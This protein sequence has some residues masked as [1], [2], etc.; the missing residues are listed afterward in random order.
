M[1]DYVEST[2]QT[3]EMVITNLHRAANLIRNFKEVAADQNDEQKRVFTLYGYIESLLR[4]LE[5]ELKSFKISVDLSGDK[6]VQLNSYPSAYSQIITNFIINSLK[7]GFKRQHQ[8][9]ISIAFEIH[10]D[11]LLLRY[12]DDGRGIDANTLPK[13]FD[14]FFT[15]QRTAGGT[16]LGLHIV[17]NI[18]NQRLG[19]TIDASSEVGAGVEFTIRVPLIPPTKAPSRA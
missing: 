1:N 11:T 15:T 4:S 3:G 19:G 13:I 14:P 12:K 6:T 16:G 10:G 18:V 5:G 8:H 9:H 2:L 17:Y 7:H